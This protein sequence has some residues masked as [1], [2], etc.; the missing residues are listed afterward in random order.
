[1]LPSTPI[2]PFLP[3]TINQGKKKYIG[4]L[5]GNFEKGG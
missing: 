1:M 4:G 3:E 5:N 2:V